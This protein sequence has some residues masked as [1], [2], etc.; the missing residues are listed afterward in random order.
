MS[1]ALGEASTGVELP[2]SGTGVAVMRDADLGETTACATFVNTESVGSVN[3][4][5]LCDRSGSMKY[6]GIK[7]LKETLQL[8]LR[9]L[10]PGS[11]FNTVSFGSRFGRLYDA[12]V[13]YTDESLD[14][15]AKAVA[16]FKA[17]YGGTEIFAPLEALMQGT[18]QVILLT[19]GQIDE[20]RR[21]G[22]W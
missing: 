19:D 12:P 4:V 3:V 14:F 8:F 5:F 17:N 10:P 11:T 6:V 13:A 2:G 18:T 16:A 1:V 22:S 9:Q 15:C 7:A 21:S 20:E